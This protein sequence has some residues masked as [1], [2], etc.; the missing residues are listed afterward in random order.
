M[1]I[2]LFIH[3]FIETVWHLNQHVRHIS[4]G[5]TRIEFYFSLFRKV[6]TYWALNHKWHCLDSPN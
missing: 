3:S 1:I 4:L 6:N 2:Y 5:C